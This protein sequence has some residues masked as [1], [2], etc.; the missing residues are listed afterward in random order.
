M[1]NLIVISPPQNVPGEGKLLHALFIEGLQYYH[2]RKPGFTK[3]QLEEKVKE[4]R[5]PF[6]RNII[7]HDHY[8]L[9]E[10]YRL[11]GIHITQK[12]KGSGYER[13]FPKYHKSISCHK[14]DEIS[15]LGPAYRYAFL[16]PVFNSIS[17]A[18]YQSKFELTEIHRFFREHPIE[19]QVIALG[20][21]DMESVKKITNTGFHGVAVLG[22]IWNDFM[23]NQDITHTIEKFKIMQQF[24]MQNANYDNLYK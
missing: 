24:T 14:L 10:K 6:R 17:K 21:I 3:L 9:V 2:L 7:L 20:G 8:E 11:G 23:E 12:N 4:I 1:E 15:E 22:Y 18:N 5:K 19:T 13:Q 16:S